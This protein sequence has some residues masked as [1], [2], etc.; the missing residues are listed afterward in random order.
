LN[1]ESNIILFF[2]FL[3]KVKVSDLRSNYYSFMLI[4]SEE[5]IEI[6]KRLVLQV[7]V[8]VSFMKNHINPIF[9]GVS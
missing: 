9:L 6:Q 3:D 5:T 8:P 1:F 4:Q 2:P 7:L